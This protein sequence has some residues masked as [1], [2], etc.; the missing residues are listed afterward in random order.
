MKLTLAQ[1]Q[2]AMRQR[3]AKKLAPPFPRNRE[4]R[5]GEEQPDTNRDLDAFL[6]GLLQRI[7]GDLSSQR[8]PM[9]RTNLPMNSQMIFTEI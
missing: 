3:W 6:E 5:L 4:I 9:L 7:I 2:A 8:F 1:K